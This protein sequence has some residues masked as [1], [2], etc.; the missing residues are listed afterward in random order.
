MQKNI[1]Y[2]NF[3]YIQAKIIDMRIIA[4]ICKIFIKVIKF[5]IRNIQ[6]NNN[7]K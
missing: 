2:Y 4:H 5:D 7:L 6:R 1:K 3:I